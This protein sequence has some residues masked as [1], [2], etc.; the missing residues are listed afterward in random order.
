MKLHRIL[1][2]LLLLSGFALAQGIPPPPSTPFAS[3]EVQVFPIYTLNVAPVPGATLQIHGASG[4]AYYCYWAVAHYQIGNVESALGCISYAPNVL[5]GGNYVQIIPFAYPPLALNI[6]ILRTTSPTAPGGT[7]NCAVATAVTS[8]AINDQSNSLSGYTVSI[9]NPNTFLL[10]LTNE[11]VGTGSSHLLLRQGWPVPG[12]LVCDLSTG[13]GGSSGGV[14]FSCQT[15]IGDGLN[16]IPAGTYLQSF[17]YN[18]SAS[19]LT[20]SGIRCFTDNSGTSTLSA[21][22]SSGNT[23]VTGPIT[24]SPTFASG[25]QSAHV[26]IPSGGW[27]EFTFVADGTSKQ[28]TWVVTE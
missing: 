28:T 7:C 20:I 2:S 24:C 4:Q 11:V 9:L 17:C 19:T 15:G 8:G 23:L 21:T 3:T 16:A 27:V 10:T 22:D 1:L 26:T 5:S 12:T 14:P 18:D 25:A 6:D 13:C